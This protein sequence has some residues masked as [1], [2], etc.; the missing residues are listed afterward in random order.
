M[1]GSVTLAK[2]TPVNVQRT[3]SAEAMLGSDNKTSRS[4]AVIRLR[5]ISLF[6]TPPS[7]RQGLT[8]ILLQPT[9]HLIMLITSG[10]RTTWPSSQTVPFPFPEGLCHPQNSRRH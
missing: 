6:I 4:E 3:E 7:L 2:V 5:R 9:F 10:L 8:R 1:V